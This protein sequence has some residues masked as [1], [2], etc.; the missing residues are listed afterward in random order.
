M[1]LQQATL[2]EI[3][4]TK[5]WIENGMMGER[6]VML[7][8]EGCEPFEYC[9]FNYDYRYTSN[10]CTAIAAENM[11]RFLGATDPM[12]HRSRNYTAP[13]ADELREQ[14]SMITEALANFEDV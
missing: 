9:V 12:E 7:Q 6:V 3:L 1:E 5:V 13:T 10:A 8:H 2:V 4:P 14:L 11:A